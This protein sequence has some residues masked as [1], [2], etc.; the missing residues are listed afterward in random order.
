MPVNAAGDGGATDTDAGST[1][2]FSHGQSKNTGDAESYA[3]GS[4]DTLSND[5]RDDRSF[6]MGMLQHFLRPIGPSIVKP[7][8]EFPAGSPQISAP[9]SVKVECDIKERCVEDIYLYDIIPKINVNHGGPAKVR[10]SIYYFAGGAFQSPP[11]S[12]HWKF[13][14]EVGKR[15]RSAGCDAVITLVSY[16]L[17]PRSPAPVTLP[18]LQRLYRKVLVDAREHGRQ[19]LLAGDSAGANVA[20]SIAL[21]ELKENS[22]GPHASAIL[23]ICP[24]VDLSHENKEAFAI[25]SK[26]PIL[27]IKHVSEFANVWRAEWDAKDPRISPLFADLTQ[28]AG[29][30]AVHGITAGLD[31]LGPDGRKFR[32]KCEQSKVQGRWSHWEKQ[33]HCFPLTWQ[34]KLADGKQSMDW[35]VDVLLKQ[36]Q[37][38]SER[39]ET[40]NTV[41]VSDSI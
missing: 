1:H 15:L 35:I 29:V 40:N 41:H 22:T 18:H 36:L 19:L 26:D 38:E 28:L 31:V 13:G 3:D 23:A 32:E 2:S 16:P 20:L 39:A 10:A 21:Q 24:A 25:D 27:R 33:M 5:H 12:D 34:Y 8:K 6:L 30:I 37:L 9:H 17:A 14:D 7:K 4:N 11:T